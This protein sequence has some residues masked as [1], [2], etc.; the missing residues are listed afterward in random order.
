MLGS[1]I[2]A[3]ASGQ[4]GDSGYKI[5]RSLRFNAADTA[6]LE[7][8][9]PTSNKKKY[10][11]SFWMKKHA[12][13]PNSTNQTVVCAY[14][15]SSIAASNYAA[16][17]FDA[18]NKLVFTTAYT[19][20]RKTTR[21]FRDVSAWYH[22][23]IVYDSANATANDRF[24]LYVN[25]VREDTWD[26]NSTIS[27]NTELGLNGSGNSGY[28]RI[29]QEVGQFKADFSLAE[30]HWI[31]NQVKT[32]ND[33]G[34]FD[35]NNVWQPKAYSGTYGTNGHFLDFADNST[36]SALG[37]DTSG[38]SNNWTPNNL[39]V[40][41]SSFNTSQNWASAGTIT[42]SPWDIN[43]AF[44]GVF[45]GGPTDSMTGQNKAFASYNGTYTYTFSGS[46]VA[47]NTS[48]KLY[49]WK[50]G[51]L[52]NTNAG[53]TGTQSITGSTGSYTSTTY[54]SA[55]LGGYLK[56]VQCVTYTNTGPYLIKIEVDGA[57]LTDPT[58]IGPKNDSLTDTPTNYGNDTGLG[59]EV[60][61]NYATLN[62]VANLKFQSKTL[63]NGN[64]NFSGNMSGSSG[65]PT[66]FST[67]GM[68]SGKFYCEAS[69]ENSSNTSGVYVGTCDSRMFGLEVSVGG[70]YPGAA[71][72]NAYGAHGKMEQNNSII[73]TGNGTYTGGD[74][75]GIARI[76]FYV[77][78]TRTSN[79]D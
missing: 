75:I 39:D 13:V 43:H 60:R 62:P 55:Q 5:E 15:N 58:I 17:N 27:Q 61:G 67:I 76:Y 35:D 45:N 1:N 65:Y 57:I 72:G 18:S 11:F 14:L 34:E 16:I 26:T 66:A 6:Y 77:I 20:Y 44:I 31:D 52:L 30:W 74:I 49:Y 41:P 2:L 37:T 73:S 32:A 21:V 46:G 50:N 48:V 47:V 40:M 69:I 7:K 63:S 70:T 68:S 3:G 19:Q 22:I 24:I 42:G 56:N 38:N 10:T 53:L 54:T 25:G 8:N 33:F 64:L 29:G 51:G 12:N 9:L 59:G 71:G 4:G 79:I 36:V 78:F 28:H 23:V